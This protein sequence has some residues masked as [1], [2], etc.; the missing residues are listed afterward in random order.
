MTE[1]D[2]AII[3]VGLPKHGKSTT[4]RKTTLEFLTKYPTGLVLAHDMNEELVPDLTVAYKNPAEWRAAQAKGNT[5]RGASFTDCT[6]AELAALV[7]E[8]GERHNSAKNVRVPLFYPVD[9]NSENDISGPTHQG[10]LDR[11]IWS[12]RRH[13]GVIPFLN[14]QIVTDVNIK[15]WRA[16]TLIYIFAQSAQQARH[17]EETLSLPKGALDEL[18]MAPKFHYLVWRQGEG[19][20]AA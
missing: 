11:R 7:I 9:E 12:R 10:Q 3:V 2:E 13:L 4:L 6:T 18:V 20:V 15:F 19:L 14:T 16:A 17:L 1:I 5:P 8:L